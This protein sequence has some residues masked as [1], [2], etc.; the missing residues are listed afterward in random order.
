MDGWTRYYAFNVSQLPS[1]TDLVVVGHFIVSHP[2]SSFASQAW[3]MLRRGNTSY[4]MLR[5]VLT[6]T[7]YRNGTATKRV[8]KI[9]SA[10]QLRQIARDCLNIHLSPL[11]AQRVYALNSLDP[12]RFKPHP[13]PTWPSVGGA[14]SHVLLLMALVCGRA[15]GAVL[16]IRA[17]RG[18]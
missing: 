16:A 17:L 8:E 4:T 13:V 7:H 18:R 11:E 12:S 1:A 10:R 6:T 3:G 15:L 2:H 14:H 5:D 9:T